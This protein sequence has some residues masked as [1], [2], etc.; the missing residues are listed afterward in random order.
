MKVEE[1]DFIEVNEYIDE[2]VNS[3]LTWREIGELC[4]LKY[5]KEYTESKWRKPY[6]IWRKTVDSVIYSNSEKILEQELK[7]IANAK[8]RLDINRQIINQERFL[9]NED[10]KNASLV[11]MF[12]NEFLR[13]LQRRTHLDR[14]PY[15]KDENGSK[16]GINGR[17]NHVFIRSD[18]HYNGEQDLALEFSEIY[19]IIADKKE[20]YGFDEIV[21]AELGD[22]IEGASLRPSQLLALRKGMVSQSMDVVTMYVEFL[23]KLTRD[24]QLR[25]KFLIVESS[26]HTQLRQLGTGRSELPMEDLMVLISE[27]I[28]VGV[29][30]NPNIDIVSAPIII[31]EI[32]NISYIMEHGHES[33]KKE[34]YF[35]KMES[36]YNKHFQYAYMGHFHNYCSMD[37]Y[38]IEEQMM[39]KNL[40]IVP[41]SCTIPN[42]YEK[43]RRWSS[44]PAIHY[45]IDTLKG[46]KHQENIVLRQS[47]QKMVEKFKNDELVE[48]K[49]KIIKLKGKTK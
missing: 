9:L 3:G 34:Q 39:N 45:S 19:S 5:G 27:L 12:N 40:T 49:G 42:D 2:L 8:R 10:I 47:Y 16:N 15:Q 28:Q 23:N 35:Q 24:L 7:R 14:L 20:E 1:I 46:K 18:G 31:T 25:V 43:V 30:D 29:K 37:I 32:N 26:N 38:E 44:V 13:A 36:Y 41:H 17:N 33:P 4:N 21:F 6:Q 48:N 22:T 11:E